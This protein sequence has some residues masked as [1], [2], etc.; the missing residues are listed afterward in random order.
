MQRN[1]NEITRESEGI[2]NDQRV[3]QEHDV[4]NDID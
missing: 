3:D 4:E 2:P 1:G